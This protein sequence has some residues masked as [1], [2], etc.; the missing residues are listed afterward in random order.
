MSGKATDLPTLKPDG[1]SFLG[2][3]VRCAVGQYAVMSTIMHKIDLVPEEMLHNTKYL[4]CNSGGAFTMATLLNYPNMKQLWP[5]D[6]IKD[7]KQKDLETFYQTYWINPT[8]KALDKI[9]NIATKPAVFVGLSGA[10]VGVNSWINAL[11][12]F[13]MVPFSDAIGD[14]A[15]K[16]V[17]LAKN[18][19]KVVSFG[20][21]ASANS[22]IRTSAGSIMNLDIYLSSVNY[23]WSKDYS[24]IPKGK[25]SNMIGFPVNLIYGFNNPIVTDTTF[26]NGDMS[27]MTYTQTSTPM[28]QCNVGELIK[29]F[30]PWIKPKT[31]DAQPHSSTV[32]T[33][34]TDQ[35]DP[36]PVTVQHPS[37]IS[38]GQSQ[39]GESMFITLVGAS[40]SFIGC[41]PQS[42]PGITMDDCDNN[43]LNYDQAILMD[44]DKGHLIANTKEQIKN[45][46]Q[47]PWKDNGSLDLN[48]TKNP[49]YMALCD[50]TNSYDNT[51]IIPMIRAW[52]MYE[53]PTTLKQKTYTIF[54]MDGIDPNDIP[55]HSDIPSFSHFSKLF[56]QGT[57][58]DAPDPTFGLTIFDS[59]VNGYD[60]VWESSHVQD[61][62]GKDV[63]L[64]LFYYQ[65]LTTIA[66][67]FVGVEKDIKIN[68]VV[69]NPYTNM[70]TKYS[71]Y[72]DLDNYGYINTLLI[73]AAQELDTKHNW[74]SKLFTKPPPTFGCFQNHCLEGHGSQSKADCLTSCKPPIPPPPLPT[75][76]YG[77][78]SQ[79]NTK[80]CIQGKGDLTS[81]QCGLAC[82]PIGADSEI[83]SAEKAFPIFLIVAAIFVVVISI[84]AH[85]HHQTYYSS[86]SSNSSKLSRKRK[87]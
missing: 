57:G 71:T 59:S 15:F 33:D 41:T 87:L 26:F 64:K 83:Q 72:Q 4:S 54:Y 47:T 80:Q 78:V 7:L 11:A 81:A 84:V 62:E 85:H 32:Q 66:N 17:P 53:K 30:L 1:F 67:E 39:L 42:I 20:A 50:G 79:N 35:T 44:M 25:N 19:N 63:Y 38:L 10:N 82:T 13:A 24:Q 3:G 70:D 46:P 36:Q 27:Q 16:D 58:A 9:H 77:C 76:T 52:Q 45:F 14:I 40:S 5:L 73:R 18:E 43:F 56:S 65:G 31:S 12:T 34:K 86:N 37:N 74:I 22:S 69:L 49:N 2:G 29:K 6:T 68:L 48:S 61:K 51:G 23:Q 75:S 8:K 55:D 60:F 28:S 21:T